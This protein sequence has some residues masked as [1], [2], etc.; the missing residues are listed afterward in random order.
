MPFVRRL[1]VEEGKEPPSRFIANWI[2]VSL[3]SRERAAERTL[4]DFVSTILGKVVVMNERRGGFVRSKNV[5]RSANSR[6]Q[7]HGMTFTSNLQRKAHQQ[8]Q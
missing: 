6:H 2:L 8:P 5:V 3:V 1:S 4:G 7:L